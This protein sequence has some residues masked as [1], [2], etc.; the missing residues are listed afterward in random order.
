MLGFRDFIGGGMK[1]VRGGATWTGGGPRVFR[2]YGEER[3]RSRGGPGRGS[4]RMA[5]LCGEPAEWA[6]QQFGACQLGD[7]R[8]N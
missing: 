7:R 4:G 6:E 8:R 3:S 1:V 2:E 5:A